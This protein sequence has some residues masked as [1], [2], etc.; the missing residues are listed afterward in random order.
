MIEPVKRSMAVRSLD[1]EVQMKRKGLKEQL[2]AKMV[3]DPLIR[4]KKLGMIEK[5]PYPATYSHIPERAV[6]CYKLTE[7][8]H[9]AVR[10]FNTELKRAYAIGKQYK[11]SYLEQLKG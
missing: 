10:L 11:I 7:K 8:G 2:D 5:H 4:V 6:Y 1:Y 9:E 3:I